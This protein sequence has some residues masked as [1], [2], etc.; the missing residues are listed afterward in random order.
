MNCS[1]VTIST[2]VVAEALGGHYV[3]GRSGRQHHEE[4]PRA[5]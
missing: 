4:S 3:A 1:Y 2:A 5:P